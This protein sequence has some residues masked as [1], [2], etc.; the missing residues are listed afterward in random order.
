ML[1][2]ALTALFVSSLVAGQVQVGA[3]RAVTIDGNDNGDVRF[4]VTGTNPCGAVHIEYGD[5]EAITT[6]IEAL[7]A[8]ITHRYARSG[9][10]AIVARGMGNCEGR[11]ALT[12]R[13]VVAPP[14]PA[15]APSPSRGRGAARG[16]TRETDASLRFPEMDRNDDGVI[17]RDEWQGSVGSF[18][19]HDWNR[20]GVLSGA[21]VRVGQAR[22]EDTNADPSRGGAVPSWSRTVFQRLDRDGNTRLTY[23]EWPY[24]IEGFRR[25]DVNDDRVLTASE[26]LATDIDDDRD[27]RFDDLDLNNDQ[28]I[29]QAEWHG[30][31]L[32]FDRID[33][34]RDGRLSR[35]EVTG[36]TAAAP[37]AAAPTG[38]EW[39]VAVPANVAWIDT[40]LTVRAG[41]ELVISSRGE[42]ALSQRAG[43]RADAGGS[44][45][46]RVS[47]RSPLPRELVG[48][49]IG[50]V[51]RSAPFAVSASGEPM[52]IPRSG[53]LYLGV[54][55]DSFTDNSGQ[56]DV[57][58]R[59]R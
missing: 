7:P 36:Q 13:T 53:R 56:F 8:T 14:A 18:R 48:T 41:D 39:R 57:T 32:V 4:R 45:T 37:T 42:I 28:F 54:N 27:D 3:I 19:V 44:L 38:S 35:S 59:R 55:D 24:D 49:L 6:P 5:G 21:E 40:G 31:R 15:A 33:R 10:Y 50:S 46:G 12:V 43:D 34:N 17:T 23:D 52:L 1:T 26:F 51:D 20:D 22:P 29:S 16:R 30:S 2:T 9:D 58:I 47:G 25:A 11:T